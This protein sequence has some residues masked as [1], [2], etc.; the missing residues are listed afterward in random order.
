MRKLRLRSRSKLTLLVWGKA[1]LLIS[2]LPT[3]LSDGE[4]G[5]SEAASIPTLA[6]PPRPTSTN[7]EKQLLAPRS[8]QLH[9]LP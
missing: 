1:W 9:L 5:T 3:Q 7:L 4:S 2:D 6:H 8:F